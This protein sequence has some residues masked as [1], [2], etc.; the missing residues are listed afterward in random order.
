MPIDADKFMEGQPIIE[1]VTPEPYGEDIAD[2]PKETPVEP[3][4]AKAVAPVVPA[5]VAVTPAPVTPPKSFV[6]A[7]PQEP[8]QVV[9]VHVVADLRRKNRELK[10]QLERLGA[11][12]PAQVNAEIPI[13]TPIDN[14]PD[15]ELLTAGQFKKTIAQVIASERASAAQQ[16]AVQDF[17]SRA[18][19]DEQAVRSQNAD[20]DQTMEAA[21]ALNLIG[22]VERIAARQQPNPMLFLYETASRRIAAARA[23]LVPLTAVAPA[24][25]KNPEPSTPNEAVEPGATQEAILENDK[26]FDSLLNKSGTT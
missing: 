4:P 2:A 10:E 14:L 21:T 6:D 24:K 23:V 20:Y 25:T 15:D 26:F 18:I 12:G 22:Q 16:R 5:A 1:E 11:T 13:V 9:P 7:E 17:N 19:A 3:E 8:E